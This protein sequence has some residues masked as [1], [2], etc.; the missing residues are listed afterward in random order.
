MAMS[1][2]YGARRAAKQRPRGRAGSR[3]RTASRLIAESGNSPRFVSS[4]CPRELS[5]KTSGGGLPMDAA[6]N[7]YLTNVHAGS[8]MGR[9]LRSYWIP[10]LYSHELPQPDGP[11]IR[12]CLLG[13][14]LV[15]FRDTQGRVGLLDHRCPHRLASLFYGRNEAGGLRCVY[16]G[17]KFDADGRCIDMP[18]APDDCPLQRKVRATAY[19]CREANGIIWTFMGETGR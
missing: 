7:A 16:H 2:R 3:R 4:Y 11:P 10:V 17:W 12:I 14:S 19:P 13:E 1:C 9:L 15:A 18:N 5:V 8:A 6:T